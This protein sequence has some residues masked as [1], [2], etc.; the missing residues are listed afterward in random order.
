MS[1]CDR[2]ALVGLATAQGGAQRHSGIEAALERARPHVVLT[3][4]FR[5]GETLTL[6]LQKALAPVVALL[7]RCRPSAI[8]RA[9]WSV[10]VD[11]IQ[12]VLGRWLRPHVGQEGLKASLPPS[13][14]RNTTAAPFFV[15]MMRAPEA[16]GLQVAPRVVF[17]R[18]SIAPASVAV[19][20]VGL[21]GQVGMQ[22]AATLRGARSHV[23]AARADA[24]AAV[25]SA[26]PVVSA[27][28]ASLPLVGRYRQT[29]VPSADKIYQFRHTGRIAQ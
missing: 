21:S 29:P 25:T 24:C 15:A 13:A 11:A 6:Q 3:R 9:I 1:K 10:V 4:P 17:R 22:A 20:Q 16:T 12:R 23:S 7:K 19:L 28:G 5:Y 18:S 2:V 14:H 8:L 27:I 26:R